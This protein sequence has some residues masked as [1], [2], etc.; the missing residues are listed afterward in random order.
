MGKINVASLLSLLP[1]VGPAIAKAPEFIRLFNEVKST[2]APHEQ[3]A[4]QAGYDAAFVHA[5]QSHAHLQDLV[6]QAGG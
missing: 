3:A 5:E 4:A 1:V 2:L 6:R